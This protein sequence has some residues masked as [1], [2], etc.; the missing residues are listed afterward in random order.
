M[1]SKISPLSEFDSY[2]IVVSFCFFFKLQQHFSGEIWPKNLLFEKHYYWII[3]RTIKYEVEC[4]GKFDSI[5][6]N[7]EWRAKTFRNWMNSEMF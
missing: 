7:L 4:R 2:F 6:R 5:E 3:L 1:F